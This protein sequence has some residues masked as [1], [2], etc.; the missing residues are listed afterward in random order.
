MPAAFIGPVLSDAARQ[1]L[2]TELESIL[3]GS[4]EQRRSFVLCVER[5]ID[6]YRKLTAPLVRSEDLLP[7]KLRRVDE[8]GEAFAKAIDALDN[9]SKIILWQTLVPE[10][11]RGED[12]KRVVDAAKWARMTSRATER[13]LEQPPLKQTGSGPAAGGERGVVLLVHN[14][15][16]LYRSIFK[17]TPS[18]S[19]EGVFS[20]ALVQILEACDVRNPQDETMPLRL[21]ETRLRSI[22][23][24][25]YN[26]SA[27]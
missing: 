24:E 1:Q 26:R 7:E 6:F 11:E 12:F 18:A 14:I 16:E 8:A 21:G 2:I 20:R 15:A 5:E 13:Y 17:R 4:P 10:L 22:L 23:R 3:P 19:R 27:E 9:T 25:L